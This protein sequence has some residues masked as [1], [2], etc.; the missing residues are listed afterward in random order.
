ML[1]FLIYPVEFLIYPVSGIMKMWH[2]LLH[3]VLGLSDSTAW[4]L[5][6]FGLIIVVRLTILPPAWMQYRAGRIYVNLRPKLSQLEEEFQ[7]RT[8]AEA[9]D[10]LRKARR[11][12]FKDH[13]YRVS[14]GCV[15]TLIQLP[16][17]MGLYQVLLRMARPTEGLHAT[18]H[19]PIGFLTSNDVATFLEGRVGGVPMPAYVAMTDEQFTFLNTNHDAVFRFALPFFISAAIFMSVNMVYSMYRNL[20]TMDYKSSF[21]VGLYKAT[22]VMAFTVPVFPI[23]FGLTGP[24]PVAISLYWFANSL[25]TMTQ[26]ITISKLL[27]KHFPLTP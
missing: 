6:I 19:A 22:I 27:D 9:D 16:M 1:R 18:T 2:I 10:E 11:K 24:A 23:S 3:S 7:D 17:F 21:A 14:A 15:P 8:D 20:L 5:S 25:W 12:L 13:D 4:M 26:Y